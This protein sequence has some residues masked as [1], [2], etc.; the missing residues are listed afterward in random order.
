M[1][2]RIDDTHAVGLQ[3][4]LGELLRF[5]MLVPGARVDSV[6]EQIGLTSSPP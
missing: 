3:R 6:H 5:G 4:E 2:E 1:D